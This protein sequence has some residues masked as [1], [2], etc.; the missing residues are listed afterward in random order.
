MKRIKHT[1]GPW[2]VDRTGTRVVDPSEPKEYVLAECHENKV[3]TIM[4]NARLIS[5]AP[6]LLEACKSA[7]ALI[8]IST[9]YKGMSTSTQLAKAIAAA[10]G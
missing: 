8:D 5:A 1:P 7:L 4:A 3:A 9:D 6:E 10:E 2:A